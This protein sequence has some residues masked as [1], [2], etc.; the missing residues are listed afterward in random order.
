MADLDQLRHPDNLR[1]AWRWLRSNPDAAYKSY[2][3]SL[4]QRYAIAEDALLDDLADRL[5]RGIYEPEPSTKLL[6]PK[7]SGILRPYSL[8]SVE[9]QIVY[10]AA[11]NLIAERLQ[12]RVVQRYNKSVFGHLYAGKTSTWFYRKWTEGYKSFNQAT[13]K[14]FADGYVYTASFDLTACYDSLDHRVLKHFLSKLGFD[15]DFCAKLTEW[16]EKWTATGRGIFHNHGIPQGPLSSGLL[17]EVVLSYFDDLKLKHSDF[18][19]LRYVDDIRL[20][21]KDEYT[22]RRL[23]VRLDEM[24]K[25]IG[26][27]PQSGKIRIHRITNIVEELKSVSNPPEAAITRQFTDQK[28]LNARIK[29]LTPRYQITNATR[30]K[31]LLAHAIPS[32]QLTARLWRIM[33]HHPEIYRSGCNYLKRYAKL[34]RVAGGKLVEVIKTNGLYASVRA[35]FISAADCRLD[36]TQDRKLARMLKK[37]WTPRSMPADLQVAIGRYLMRT[38]DLS[39]TQVAYACRA[40][41]SW[42]T[43]ASLIEAAVPASLGAMAIR[44][45]VEDGVKDDGI[46][47]ALAAGWKGFESAFVPAGKRKDWKKAVELLLRELGMIQRSTAG[48]C[49]INNAFAKL[50]V[51][52]STGNWK[53]L[54]GPRYSQA[55]LQAIETVAASGVNITGFV[56]LLDVFDDLL[57][58]AVYNAD[59]AIGNYTL[60]GIGSVLHAPTGRFAVKYPNT[61]ELAKEVH[62]RRYE[63]MASHPLIK[64]TGKPTRRISYK[65]LPTAKRL[66]R[67]SIA[68]LK[69]AGLL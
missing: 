8:L 65:F 35:E 51:R 39:A 40:A 55:E 53:K 1:R 37:I 52:V 48:H 49:G 43:R 56:N 47:P 42:W 58:D 50:D 25:D 26:L 17:S 66:L 12:P 46:D 54:F 24:S 34:P 60:G 31:Y 16:L 11:L 62:D 59:P 21:A 67:E 9:D 64:R 19:Y 13:E 7:A 3:R 27:F 33:E 5:R 15:P 29:E 23:L 2:F 22:L 30:F 45:I 32:A 20:F 68:E 28:K 4:Y 69:A 18:R 6:H 63:S 41:P 57:I 14:A 61:Y 36:A 10:Q 44:Q 38:G